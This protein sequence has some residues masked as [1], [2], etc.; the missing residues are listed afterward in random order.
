MKSLRRH[1]L[2]DVHRDANEAAL[3][4]IM[5]QLGGHWWEGGPLDG[6]CLQRGVWV[7]VEIKRPEREGTAREY[8]P[9]QKRFISWC[10]LHNAPWHV[11]R[12]DKDVLRTMGARVSA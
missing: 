11:W 10:A 1:R 7:P 2:A 9:L 3:L 6:W 8:T 5:E 4:R 12:D